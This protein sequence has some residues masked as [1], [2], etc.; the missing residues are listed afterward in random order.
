MIPDMIKLTQWESGKPVYIS[1]DHI[2]A[3]RELPAKV[4]EPLSDDDS[5]RELGQ[6]TRIDTTTDC[7]LVRESAE[8]IAKLL[9]LD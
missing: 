5:P 3:I 6:R 7:V 2:H 9:G 8:E 1:P 4:H